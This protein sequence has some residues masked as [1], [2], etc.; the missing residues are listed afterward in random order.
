MN[1]KHLSLFILSTIACSIFSTESITCTS[2]ALQQGALETIG[3]VI[4]KTQSFE[5]RQDYAI[6]ITGFVVI[7]SIRHIQGINEFTEKEKHDFIDFLC[8]IRKLMS[9][10]LNIDTVYLIQEEDASHFHIW[11]FPRYEWMNQFGVKIKSVKPIMSWAKEHLN[12]PENIIAVRKAVDDL[13]EA[14]IIHTSPIL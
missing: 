9:K 11:L 7:S 13:K 1:Y 6:P 12:T 8:K 4:A 10:Q 5:A 2:C 14:W 3:G